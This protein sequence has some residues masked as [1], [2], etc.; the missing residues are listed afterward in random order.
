MI[1]I[2]PSIEILGGKCVVL[3]QGN[4]DNV[5]TY[6]KDPISVAKKYFEAGLDRI[7]IIDLDGAREGKIV[8][9]KILEAISKETKLKIEYGGGIKSDD[10]IKKVFEHGAN[11][12]N[13]GTV[14]VTNPKMFLSW[15][16]KYN[17]DKIVLGAD[18]FKGIV[19]INGWKSQTEI[20]LFDFITNFQWHGVQNVL[21]TDI[22]KEG[23][24]IGCSL[25]MYKA[26]TKQFPDLKIIARGGVSSIQEIQQL[27]KIGC[28]AVVIG[29]AMYEK[30]I[31]LEELVKL[32][33]S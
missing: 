19:R 8:H 2:I 7:N 20:K 25:D 14:A 4:F 29:K 26:V 1:K 33:K 15:L 32:S 22:E 17:R 24:L 12:V 16:Q 23:S 10:D 31:K 6:D 5:T 18:V 28:H 21:C 11:Q 27:D 13:I 30:T 9:H 3:S